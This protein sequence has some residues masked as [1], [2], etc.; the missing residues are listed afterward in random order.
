MLETGLK[1]T[2]TDTV[3]PDKTAKAVGSGGLEVFATPAML[4][5]MEKTSAAL[6]QPHLAEGEGTVGTLVDITHISATPLG[7]QVSCESELIEIDRK[8]L[9][10]R[11]TASDERGKIGEG[12]HERFI[13]NN[14]CFMAKVNSK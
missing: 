4:A 7:M 6:A 10:F 2:L 11:V 1:Y 8:R 9:V 3:T 14:N 12:A 13:I 5:L